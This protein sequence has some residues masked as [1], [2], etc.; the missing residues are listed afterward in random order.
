MALDI[1]ISVETLEVSYQSFLLLIPR[2]YEYVIKTALIEICYSITFWKE[3]SDTRE[4]EC[5]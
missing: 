4:C 3:E 2:Y 1:S 5:L